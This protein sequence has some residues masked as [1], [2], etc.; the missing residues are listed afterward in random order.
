VTTPEVIV[1]V[2]LADSDSV[3]V[4][5]GPTLWHESNP[6]QKYFVIA[7]SERGRGFRCDQNEFYRV[8]FRKILIADKHD[9]LRILRALVARKPALVIHD[10]EGAGEV[11]MARLCEALWPGERIS[12]L[13]AAVE[14]EH[15]SWKTRH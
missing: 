1:E 5:L 6:E 3:H 8:A 9:R 11:Y 12:R 2:A 14:E 15:K 13:R 7:T 4:V 10:C